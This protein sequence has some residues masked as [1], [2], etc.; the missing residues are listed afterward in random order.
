MF[1]TYNH[2]ETFYEVIQKDLIMKK[3]KIIIL[4][5]TNCKYP[6]EMRLRIKNAFNSPDYS[7]QNQNAFGD[8]IGG[9]RDNTIVEIK[10]TKTLCKE[11]EPGPEMII[12]L[13]QISMQ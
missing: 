2:Y 9:I 8:L 6:D 13:M 3:P 12:K 10:G 1:V 5:L 4:N 11:F 7:G